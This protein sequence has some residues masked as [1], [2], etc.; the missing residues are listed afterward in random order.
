MV[1]EFLKTQSINPK[2]KDYVSTVNKD[3]EYLGIK[4]SFSEIEIMGKSTYKKL[5]KKKIREHKIKIKLKENLSSS[6]GQKLY[7]R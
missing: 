7:S 1:K 3:L 4:L 2:K 6:S 5:I